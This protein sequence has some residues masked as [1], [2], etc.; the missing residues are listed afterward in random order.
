MLVRANMSED[1]RLKLK[2]DEIKPQLTYDAFLWGKIVHNLPQYSISSWTRHHGRHRILG[3][4]SSFPPQGIPNTCPR[5]SQSRASRIT[6]SWR[7]RTN[8]RRFGINEISGRCPE[9]NMFS[10]IPRLS[11]AHLYFCQETLRF[12]SIAIAIIREA[13]RDDAIPLSIPQKTVTGNIVTSI[14]I[15]CGQ[16][17]VISINAYNRYIYTC[18][19]NG[20]LMCNSPFKGF[21]KSGDQTRTL[22]TQCALLVAYNPLRR[23]H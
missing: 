7:R 19:L 11:I 3:I 15:S 13:D 10:D 22:G 17:V 18:T 6:D 8:Y 4:I 9:S 5:R 21:R 23:L 1:P 16:K 12:D 14:P 2:N 20:T